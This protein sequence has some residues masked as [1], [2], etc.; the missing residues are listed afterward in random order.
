MAGF[1]RP[2]RIGSLPPHEQFL[3]GC[4]DQTWSFCEMTSTALKQTKLKGPLSA[5][6]GTREQAKEL[7]DRQLDV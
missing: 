5:R 4:L 3:N 2:P 7:R 1:A 6:R